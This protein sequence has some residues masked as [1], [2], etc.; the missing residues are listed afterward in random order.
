MYCIEC[1]TK[2]IDRFLE[3]EGIVPYCESCGEYRF[4][5]FSTACSMIVLD[6]SREKILL[7][8]QYGRD[9][10]ILVAGYISKGENAEHTVRREVAEEIGIELSELHYNKSGYFG[11]SNTLMLN[12]WCVAQS[13][14]LKK[15]NYEV[16]H[17]EWYTF[18]EA[19]RLVTHGSLAEEFLLHF[20]ENYRPPEGF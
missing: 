11:R 17:A 6:P 16:D 7:I 3:H 15:T 2:L 20:L 13:D 18:D 5:P 8:K 12:F 1:G 14:D 19:R 10:N 9:R 4:P